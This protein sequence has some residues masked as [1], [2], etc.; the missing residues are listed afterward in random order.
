MS[1]G[2]KKILVVEDE[3]PLAMALEI[4]LQ[5]RGYQV[6]VAHDGETG[7]ALLTKSHYDAVLLDLVMPIMDGF[8]VLAA[9]QKLPTPP[10]FIVLSNLTQPDDA[11]RS[12]K[13]GAR[14][15]LV[16]SETPLS[17]IVKEIEAL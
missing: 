13:L 14:K 7:L 8:E 17:E 4:T 16:K 2:T 1:S 12:L 11:T 3:K 10:A 15:F 6:A 9:A 5:K